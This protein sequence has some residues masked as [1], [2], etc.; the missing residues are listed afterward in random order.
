M[1]NSLVGIHAAFGELGIFAFLWAFVELINP[2][3]QR[4][5]R[6]KIA[7]MIGVIFFFLSWFVGGFYYVSFYGSN[8]KPLIKE[9]PM[10]WAHSIFTET[11]EHVFLF[12]PFL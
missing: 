1:V 12:L 5:K 4:V 10:P 11:K 6:A 8:V 7:A 2:T 9:G 3:Q